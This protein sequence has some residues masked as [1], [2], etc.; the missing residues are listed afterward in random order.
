[1]Q[2]LNRDYVFRDIAGK[3]M[4]AIDVFSILIKYFKDWLIRCIANKFAYGEIGENDID[5]V[6]TLPSILGD[7]AILFFREAAMKVSYLYKTS[8]II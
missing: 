3:P 6:F 1:M 8:Y 7:E 4:N 5:F 2:D